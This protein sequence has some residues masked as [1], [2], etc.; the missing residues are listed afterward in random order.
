MSKISGPKSQEEI[1][2]EIS[3][4]FG[5][6][7]IYD[8]SADD[9]PDYKEEDRKLKQEQSE[10]YEMIKKIII[11][12]KKINIEGATM[13]LFKLIGG[14]LAL[15]VAF[16]FTFVFPGSGAEHIVVQVAAAVL[17][18]LGISN[19]RVNYGLAKEWYKD[20]TIVPSILVMVVIIGVT[21][22]S[23]FDVGLSPLVVAI[24]QGIVVALGG[25]G[26]WG[27][28]D[29]AKLKN[30]NL[31]S[32]V[33]FI[34]AAGTILALNSIFAG[35][36]VAGISF[37]AITALSG[38]TKTASQKTARQRGFSVKEAIGDATAV[39]C[40]PDCLKS[41][42]ISLK[43]VNDESAFGE[44]TIGQAIE[45]EVIIYAAEAAIRTFCHELVSKKIEYFQGTTNSGQTYTFSTADATPAVRFAYDEATLISEKDDP[46]I[47]K[48][49]IT[50][51]R[52][53]LVMS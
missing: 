47:I 15:I 10:R 9:L 18:A 32:I 27:I 53:N 19:W 45:G 40:P 48:L 11:G 28:F 37:A 21:A 35:L 16:I 31:K 49:K 12:L 26:L 50:G 46:T 22:L 2:K 8:N 3:G 36:T 52:D 24:L 33:A 5:V 6:D 20:K 23:F 34:I 43:G 44:E 29:A 51:Y 4:H 17:G 30:D 14:G 42:K 41:L 7:N 39:A 38:Q 13:T 1:D 25:V